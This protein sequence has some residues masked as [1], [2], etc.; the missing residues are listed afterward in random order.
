[1]TT[2]IPPPKSAR[3]R[4]VH[5]GAADCTEQA[6]DTD[7]CGDGVVDAEEG[8]DDGNTD[9]EECAYGIEACT[10][11]AMTVPSKRVI[12]TCKMGWSMRKRCDDGNTDTE[13]CDYGIEAHGAPL[14][15][16]IGR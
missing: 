2:A 15:V 6:G 4:S 5:G 7:V 11:C 16:R 1:M 10:V 3:H 12:R 14:T 13:E 8:C 9:T